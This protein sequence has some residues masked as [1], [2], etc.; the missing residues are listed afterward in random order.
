MELSK[1]FQSHKRGFV[2]D[3]DGNLF[4]LGDFDDDSF[5]GMY[6][7]GQGVGLA[8]HVEAAAYLFEDVCHGSGS[9]RDGDDPVLRGMKLSGG[10]AQGDGFAAADIAGDDGDGALREKTSLEEK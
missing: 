9:G 3:Q 6:Q 10:M 1:D 8:V 4:S 7:P 2:N 5:K